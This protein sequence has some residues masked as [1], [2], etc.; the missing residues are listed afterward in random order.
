MKYASVLLAAS[1]L[2]SAVEAQWSNPALVWQDT[3]GMAEARL[4]ISPADTLWVAVM[5]EGYTGHTDWHRIQT[6]WNTGDSWSDMIDVTGLDSSEGWYSGMGFG[7]DPQE[8]LWLSWYRGNG[9]TF[10]EDSWAVCTAMRDNAG[11]HPFAKSIDSFWAAAAESFAADRQGN[12]YMTVVQCALDVPGVIESAMYS[13]LDADTW[14][15]PALIAAGM[16]SPVSSGHYSMV[17]IPHPDTG[18]WEVNDWSANRVEPR[19]YVHRVYRD[20]AL[21]MLTMVGD[22]SEATADSAGRLWVVY[23]RD[24][25]LHAATIAGNAVVDSAVITNDLFENWWEHRAISVCTDPS[26]WIWAT[27]VNR[28]RQSFVSYNWG[29]GWSRPE[30]V[31]DSPGRPYGIVSDSRGRVFVLAWLRRQGEW[32]LY[33]TYRLDRPGIEE[34]PKPRAAGFKP[35]ATV[36]RG[37]PPGVVAFDAMG[38]RVLSA[39]AGV[40][41]LREEPQ[42][43]SHKPQA[44]RKVVLQ[45]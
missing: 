42:A 16:G 41:F 13:R 24:S 40:Y 21:E 4:L 25:L 3:T 36:V 1:C 11:W 6:A 39:K 35:A 38:R 23:A 30:L 28:D 32:S 14:T 27:W 12:W 33:T 10:E 7:C 26:G 17:L 37:L 8:R 34:D 5:D 22:G 2:L 44:V 31:C 15:R 9:Y 29:S 20:T 19:V 43:S 45:R 18:L